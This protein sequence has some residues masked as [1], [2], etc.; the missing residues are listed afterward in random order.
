MFGTWTALT[1]AYLAGLEGLYD[2]RY[3]L[4]LLPP[5]GRALTTGLVTTLALMAVVIPIGFS[6]G[7]TF[8]WARTSHSWFPRALAATYVE[9]FRGMPPIVLIAFAFLITIVILRGNDRVDVFPFATSV[10]VLALAAHSGAYQAEIVRAGILSADPHHPPP[11]VPGLPPRARERAGVP[12]Q[13][14][15][16]PLH[17]WG[18][19]PH[20]PRKEPF[21]GPRDGRREH[22][23]RHRHLGRDRP[24]VLCDHVRR[25]KD[26]PGD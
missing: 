8:G 2:L 6:L 19:R 12:D 22:R 24:P 15:V 11:D 4:S 21:R 26:A 18:A 17:D 5:G 1:L 7:F 25:D 13:G 14:H 9:F 16:A 3:A 20:L 23:S 10:S